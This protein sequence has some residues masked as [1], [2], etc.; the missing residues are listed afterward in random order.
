MA[1]TSTTQLQ[2]CIERLKAG[3]P[4]ARDELLKHSCE[5][6]RRLARRM[7]QDFTRVKR[8]ED[9]DDVLQNAL[10]RLVR[11]LQA[12][13]PASVQEFFRLAATQIRRE[14]LDLARRYYGPEGLGRK[15]E[16]D[17]GGGVAAALPYEPANTTFDPS[18]LAAWSEFHQRIEALPSEE[19]VVF[20]L[21]WYQGLTRAEAAAVLGVSEA[22]V[23]RRWLAARL[24]LQDDLPGTETPA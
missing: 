24:R 14:L 5:R 3:D 9:T 18:R 16:S 12:V 19:R 6:L 13:P 17:A 22:T 10:L 15:H 11:A 8:W 4:T 7:L 1:E 20:D 23:K 21:L 2:N